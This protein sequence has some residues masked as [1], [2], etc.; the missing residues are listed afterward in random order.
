MDITRFAHKTFVCMQYGSMYLYMYL[1]QRD[2][3]NHY[4]VYDEY[5]DVLKIK[6]GL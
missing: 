4:K 2:L 3:A 6:K 1:L 5:I